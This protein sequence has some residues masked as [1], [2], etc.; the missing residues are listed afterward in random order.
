MVDI[1]FFL[2]FDLVSWVCGGVGLVWVDEGIG[3]GIVDVEVFEVE[4][5]NEIFVMRG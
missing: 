4:I 1:W 5:K 3:V 2:V